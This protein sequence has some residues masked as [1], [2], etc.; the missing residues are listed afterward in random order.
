MWTLAAGATAAAP[1]GFLVAVDETSE[2][3]LQY[4][5]VGVL[6]LLAVIAVR[7]L[8]AREVAAHD[9]ERDRADRLEA[10]LRKQNELIQEK[11]VTALTQAQSAIQEAMSLMRD[12]R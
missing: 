9:R 6:A 11:F 1:L 8:F 7:V 12:R 5:A 3:L 2:P 10:E 4:G